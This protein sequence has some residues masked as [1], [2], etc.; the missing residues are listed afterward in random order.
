MFEEALKFGTLEIMKAGVTL[1]Q[2]GG[3]EQMYRANINGSKFRTYAVGHG[4]SV[5]LAV[6][7]AVNYIMKNPWLLLP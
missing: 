6:A 4:K 7:D 5:E 3:P 2:D 1:K